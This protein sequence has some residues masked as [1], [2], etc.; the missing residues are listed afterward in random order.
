M[1]RFVKESIVYLWESVSFA[2]TRIVSTVPEIPVNAE[3]VQV[4]TLSIRMV[5]VQIAMEIQ[6]Q[7]N[8]YHVILMEVQQFVI[9][10]T[11]VS[12]LKMVRA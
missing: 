4:V 10:A 8:V 12:V 11:M 1:A 5:N 7:F 9:L 6:M 2:R 3:L